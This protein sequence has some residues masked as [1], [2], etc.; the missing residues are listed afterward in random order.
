MSR[1]R[2]AVDAF[3]RSAIFFL[4]VLA[5]AAVIEKR[6]PD[7]AGFRSLF[8]EQVADGA[9]CEVYREDELLAPLMR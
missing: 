2:S 3:S 9:A 6:V 4:M 7:E 1:M 5:P 8:Q